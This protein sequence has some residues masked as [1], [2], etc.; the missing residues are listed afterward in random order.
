MN[1]ERFLRT[2]LQGDEFPTSFIRLSPGV[3]PTSQNVALPSVFFT[4]SRRLG[5]PAEPGSG[6]DK[7]GG[8]W[9]DFGVRV[10]GASDRGSGFCNVA[11]H[12]FTNGFLG[13]L[14]WPWGAPACP[15]Q[16]PQLSCPRRPPAQASPDY[17]GNSF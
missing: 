13:L 8:I 11:K 1:W 14:G 7:G 10:R 16:L 15:R 3:R 2:W 4:F 12:C 9:L 6:P 17:H 5:A